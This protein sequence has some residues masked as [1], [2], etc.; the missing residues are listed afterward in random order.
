MGTHNVA[1]LKDDVTSIPLDEANADYQ[2]YIED[3]KIHGMSILT[4]TDC[5]DGVPDK[6]MWQ[7]LDNAEQLIHDKY[8]SD[9]SLHDKI[10][11]LREHKYVKAM[12]AEFPYESMTDA[13]PIIDSTSKEIKQKYNLPPRI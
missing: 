7:Y 10:T 12:K 13:G 1:V 8:H 6:S 5:C 9:P 4:C 2:R 3:L 11:A